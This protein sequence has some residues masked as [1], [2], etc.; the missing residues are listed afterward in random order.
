VVVVIAVL[1]ISINIYIKEG[2]CASYFTL[3]AGVEVRA[4]DPAG[5]RDLELTTWPCT[6][7][8]VAAA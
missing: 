7:E 8:F 2:A 1:G 5:P 4:I 6:G 3:V